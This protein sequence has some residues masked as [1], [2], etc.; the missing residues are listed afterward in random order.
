MSAKNWLGASVVANLALIGLIAFQF[1]Q[2][3][4]PTG[5]V[6]RPHEPPVK[7][8]VAQRPG[9][10]ERDMMIAL[11][12]LE[13]D[14]RAAN[15]PAL[16]EFWRSD[17]DAQLEAYRRKTEEQQD[18]IRQ[19]LIAG[20]GAE[21]AKNPI[22]AR[23]FRPLDARFPYL[24]STSQLALAKLQRARASEAATS[25]LRGVA[26][27][28]DIAKA[29]DREREFN[30]AVRAAFTAAE[31]EEYCLRESTAA[32]Q[33]R[34]S[35]VV[36]N[37]QEFRAAIETLQKMESDRTPGAYLEVQRGLNSLLGPERF[38]RFLASR[39]PAFQTI[40]G[41][42]VA[43]RLQESQTLAVYEAIVTAQLSVLEAQSK[44]GA[45]RSQAATTIRDIVSSRDAR[46]VSLV[47]EEPAREILNA[48]TNKLMSMNQR[49][50]VAAL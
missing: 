19:T 38:V 36:V 11:A 27:P 30:R 49:R 9:V 34:A 20:Y 13:M 10:S 25:A 50:D 45:D 46:I 32:R 17:V 43:Q 15:P 39:D 47:G 37:E 31:F 41:V 12:T 44:A 2:A 7:R 23:I 35:G 1:E 48:Y 42:A 26:V 18:A 5:T 29:L 3:E 40:R 22:F 14:A 8:V 4:R 33:L 28:T 16:P 6:I 21:A 24:S